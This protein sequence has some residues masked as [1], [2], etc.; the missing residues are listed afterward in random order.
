[1]YFARKMDGI[2]SADLMATLDR[3]CGFEPWG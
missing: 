2:R 1:M 3:D